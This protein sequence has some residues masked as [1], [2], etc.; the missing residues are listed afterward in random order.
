MKRL[1][2][3]IR[4]GEFLPVEVIAVAVLMVLVG[5]SIQTC[6]QV[7]KV[8][9]EAEANIDRAVERASTYD[10]EA[11]RREEVWLQ[12]KDSIENELEK[13]HHKI[14]SMGYDALQHTLDSLYNYPRRPLDW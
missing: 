5:A 1:W 8:Q 10:A 3:W 2:E 14:D 11:L 4:S 6:Q 7:T 13:A 12:K 9:E